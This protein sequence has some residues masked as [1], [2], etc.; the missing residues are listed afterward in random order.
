MLRVCPC[1]RYPGSIKPSVTAKSLLIQR[2]DGGTSFSSTWHYSPQA[3]KMGDIAMR[4]RVCGR[5]LAGGVKKGYGLL[6]AWHGVRNPRYDVPI[7]ADILL[8]SNQSDL[9]DERRNP[10]R[11]DEDCA[12]WSRITSAA[13]TSGTGTC[14]VEL[15]RC[16]D[17]ANEQSRNPRRT[18]QWAGSHATGDRGGLQPSHS[19]FPESRQLILTRRTRPVAHPSTT[20]LP[21]CVVVT[22]LRECSPVVGSVDAIPS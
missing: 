5:C 10:G 8:D 9:Y 22:D 1:G 18:N 2:S 20:T 15:R 19:P 14:K 17:S 11:G 16:T 13:P 21:P 12:W 4:G 3:S 7:L 6:N